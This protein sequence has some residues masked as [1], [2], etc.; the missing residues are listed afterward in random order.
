M[1]TALKKSAFKKMGKASLVEMPFLLVTCICFLWAL[2]L[3]LNL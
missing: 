3:F 2:F 1:N